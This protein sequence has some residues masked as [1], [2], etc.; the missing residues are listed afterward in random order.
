MEILTAQANYEAQVL[1]KERE[2]D[3][4]EGALSAQNAALYAQIRAN[5]IDN[6]NLEIVKKVQEYDTNLVNQAKSFFGNLSKIELQ[7]IQTLSKQHTDDLALQKDVIRHGTDAEINAANDKYDELIRQAEKLNIDTKRIEEDRYN[8]ILLIQTAGQQKLLD[9]DIAF[10][11][12]QIKLQLDATDRLIK[13]QQARLNETLR[14]TKNANQRA[15]LSL[16]SQLLQNAASQS[17]NASA[18]LTAKG[19]VNTILRN[20]NATQEQRNA[21]ENKGADLELKLSKLQLEANELQQAIVNARVNRVT[22][23]VS[24]VNTEI[25]AL[26]NGLETFISIEQ[27]KTDTLITCPLYTFDPSYE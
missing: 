13:G 1:D 7:N 17:G 6:A 25:Q 21:A 11:E 12:R 15:L 10:A 24:D 19:E 20:P 23:V 14:N 22:G 9:A 16:Q 2:K 5:I 18:L 4:K 27:Q 3:R 26:G 8:E